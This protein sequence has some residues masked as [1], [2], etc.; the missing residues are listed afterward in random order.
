MSRSVAV[1]GDLFMRAGMFEEA[2]RAIA[3]VDLT[4]RSMELQWPDEAMSHGYSSDTAGELAALREFMGNPA[5][6]ASFVGD[7][8]IFVDH[9]APVTASMLDQLP[10]LRLI[11]VSRGG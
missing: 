9:L 6:I 2:L 3:G 8:E 1:V 7:A 11:A 10:N 4:I 5:E